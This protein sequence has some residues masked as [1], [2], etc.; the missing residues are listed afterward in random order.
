MEELAKNTNNSRTT[1]S[2]K[3]NSDSRLMPLS[4]PNP[5]ESEAKKVTKMISPT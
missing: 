2:T 5:T 1:A 3:F 4:K